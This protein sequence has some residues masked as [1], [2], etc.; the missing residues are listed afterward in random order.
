MPSQPPRVSASSECDPFSMAT[1]VGLL[2][3][4]IEAGGDEFLMNRGRPSH[5]TAAKHRFTVG[6]RASFDRDMLRIRRGRTYARRLH[7]QAAASI[8]DVSRSCQEI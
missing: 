8:Y 2:L 3:P 4:S 5:S 7:L 1:P 6:L